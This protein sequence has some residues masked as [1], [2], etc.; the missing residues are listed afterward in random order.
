MRGKNRR[1]N[2]NAS[3]SSRNGDELAIEAPRKTLEPPTITYHASARSIVFR[4]YLRRASIPKDENLAALDLNEG[5]LVK[6][7]NSPLGV[8]KLSVPRYQQPKI[9]PLPPLELGPREEFKAL[10]YDESNGTVSPGDFSLAEK[11]VLH[12]LQAQTAVVKTIK[13]TEWPMFLQRFIRSEGRQTGTSR[14][15]LHRDHLDDVSGFNS[16]VTSTSILPPSGRKM[17]CYGSTNQYTTG[18]VFAL[19]TFENNMMEDSEVKRTDTW[20]WPAGYAAKVRKDLW[21]LNTKHLNGY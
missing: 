9:Q 16:F 18:V 3:D 2:S 11:E 4:D 21:R 6:E 1:Q 13:N 17:R 5:T 10:L 7:P 20:A 15:V 14:N 19:P 8:M 12:R